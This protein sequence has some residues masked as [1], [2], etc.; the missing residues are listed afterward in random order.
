V[1]PSA[2]VMVE[3]GEAATNAESKKGVWCWECSDNS[4][5][6]KDCKVKHYCYICDKK[7][8]PTAC[9]PVHKMPRPY[10]FVS[11]FGLLE[12]YFTA[13][14]DYMV[15]EDLTPSQSPIALVVVTGNVVPADVIAR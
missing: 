4:H 11:G 2:G 8:H 10:V 12:T 3:G 15:N 1:V 5:A 13:F 9:C 14:P 7:A 6:A